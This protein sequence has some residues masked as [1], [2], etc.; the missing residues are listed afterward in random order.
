MKYRY[1]STQRPIAPGTFPKPIDN[2]IL[3]IKDFE[4]RS[5]VG[6]IGREAWGYL[7]YEKPLTDEQ[8]EAYELVAASDAEDK[9]KICKLLCKVLQLTRGASDLTALDYDGETEIVTATFEGGTRKINVACDSGTAMIR[10]IVN[11][12]GC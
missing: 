10:D 5:Y 9:N 2:P 1:F 7:E 3:N 11:K 12:L 4:T 8:I 6:K